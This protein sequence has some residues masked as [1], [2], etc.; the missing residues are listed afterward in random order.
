MRAQNTE[1]SMSELKSG[2][3]YMK[4]SDKVE[5]PFAAGLV[6]RHILLGRLEMGHQVSE[7]GQNW[8]LVKDVPSL[9][10]EVLKTDDDDPIHQER[11]MAARRWA[12]E[13]LSNERRGDSPDARGNER[14][15]NERRDDELDDVTLHRSLLGGRSKKNKSESIFTA[16][17]FLFAIVILIGWAGYYAYQN[18]PEEVVVDCSA[19]PGYA[20]NWTNCVLLSKDLRSA[21]LEKALLRNARLSTANLQSANLR[22]ADMAYVDLS[23]ANL[24]GA[25]MSSASL[26]GASLVGANL[27]G[28]S[29][30][31]TDLSFANLTDADIRSTDL[32]GAILNQAIWLDGS[33]CAADAIGSCN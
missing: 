22:G 16:E 20:V 4:R 26:K 21:N 29:L 23:R 33:V 32:S 9:I 25:D 30:V 8:H 27:Q 17:L 15:G 28:A 3:W 14:R 31:N 5:G 11:L 18:K 7:D 12:D 1:F 10:P 2:K 6:S 24:N 19:V 13:R